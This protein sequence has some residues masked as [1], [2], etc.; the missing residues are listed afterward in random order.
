[1]LL[2]TRLFGLAL[3]KGEADE[4]GKGNYTSMT[5][6]GA[7][8]SI[9]IEPVKDVFGVELLLVDVL[10]L[11]CENLEELVE[12]WTAGMELQEV[13]PGPGTVHGGLLAPLLLALVQLAFQRPVLVQLT[14]IQAAQVH[15]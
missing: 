7:Y 14:R 11:V 6:E 2:L 10:E 9:H 5:S 4:N 13:V 3:L 12:V 15:L 1:M 8:E